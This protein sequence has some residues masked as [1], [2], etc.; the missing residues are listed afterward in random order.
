LITKTTMIIEMTP[1]TGNVGA[2]NLNGSAIANVFA[3]DTGWKSTL[4]KNDAKTVPRIAMRLKNP[5]KKR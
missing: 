5:G 4:P 2:P 1:A 3:C